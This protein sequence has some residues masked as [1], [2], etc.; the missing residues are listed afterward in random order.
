[1]ATTNDL[2]RGYLLLSG[3]DNLSCTDNHSD[4]I[5]YGVQGYAEDGEYVDQDAALYVARDVQDVVGELFDSSK[6]IDTVRV[7]DTR[8]SDTVAVWGRTNQ[9]TAI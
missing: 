8:E 7:I 1:M 3:T 9:L 4:E 2:I 6:D 5:H